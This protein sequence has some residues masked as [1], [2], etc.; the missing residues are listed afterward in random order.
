MQEIHTHTHPT[1]HTHIRTF[2]LYFLVYCAVH[3]P[4]F[5][6]FLPL[7]PFEAPSRA[8]VSWFFCSR[9]CFCFVLCSECLIIL[10][11]PYF[12]VL[13]FTFSPPSPSRFTPLSWILSWHPYSHKTPKSAV[14]SL[15]LYKYLQS[16]QHK[17][18]YK[19]FSLEDAGMNIWRPNRHNARVLYNTF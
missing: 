3:L 5:L 13:V 2:L 7:F 9:R 12:Q 18:R 17:E 11:A 8:G 4:Y 15:F 16:I 14:L 10:T 19:C 1:I 6:P